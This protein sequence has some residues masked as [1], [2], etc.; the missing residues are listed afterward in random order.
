MLPS[1]QTCVGDKM[2]WD[3]RALKQVV[4][5][6]GVQRIG[7]YWFKS[8]EI[9]T[10]H[11]PA[12]VRE[13]AACAFY[14]CWYLKSVTFAEGSL[15]E[16]IGKKCFCG[17]GLQQITIPRNVTCVEDSAFQSCDYLKTICMDEGCDA[18][19]SSAAVPSFA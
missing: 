1:K 4:I 7:G 19:L 9:E 16:K 3:L 11:V 5:P 17:S 18:S 14:A 12:S 13:I 15:L 2:L 10:V 6:E 8:S